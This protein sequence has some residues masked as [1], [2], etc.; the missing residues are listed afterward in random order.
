MAGAYNS[1]AVANWFLDKYEEAGKTC[2]QLQINK[3]VFIAHGYHLAAD[4]E[5]MGLINEEVVA[6]KHGPVIP[7]LRD[8][9][10]SYG[11]LPITG[12][13]E[14]VVSDDFVYRPHLDG[15]KMAGW[16]PKMLKWV[17]ERYGLLDGPTLI[18]VTH[19]KGSPWA[20]A[21][22]NGTDIGRNKIIPTEW[23]REYYGNLLDELRSSQ[24]SG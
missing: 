16:E 2:T 7:S 22:K 14:E 8:E 5:G 19:R 15:D 21:T 4:P 20:R 23:I 17:F 11:N 12:R 24:K 13:A 10:R 1:K 9:F 6:W 3:V 18:A